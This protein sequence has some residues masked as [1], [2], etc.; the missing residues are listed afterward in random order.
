MNGLDRHLLEMALRRLPAD[1]LVFAA[2]VSRRLLGAATSVCPDQKWQ[3][4]P[5]AVTA[6]MARFKLSKW[7]F[8]PLLMA[9]AAA[10]QGQSDVL[11][12]ACDPMRDPISSVCAAAA[13]AHQWPTLFDAIDMGWW[14]N[15]A[16]REYARRHGRRHSGLNTEPTPVF[17][18]NPPIAVVPTT[19][20]HRMFWLASNA[21]K[22]VTLKVPAGGSIKLTHGYQVYTE[23]SVVGPGQVWLRIGKMRVPVNQSP[24]VLMI[25]TLYMEVWLEA[26]GELPTVV[27]AK[28]CVLNNTEDETRLG[29][30]RG[31]FG[32]MLYDS[33]FAYWL[34]KN[35]MLCHTQTEVGIGSVASAA[36]AYNG[37][38]LESA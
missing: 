20:T 7:P 13:E 35:P 31:C 18:W 28:A 17:S 16:T 9:A 12:L 4:T 33:G 22:L 25:S 24:T 32:E 27:T 14:A 11:A 10:R 34:G 38:D 26:E 19:D 36:S 2:H 6:S 37:G 3:L 8:K 21:S 23:M 15:P 5:R 29:Q 1:E 30:N